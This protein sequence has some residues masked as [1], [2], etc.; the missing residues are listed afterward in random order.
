MLIEEEGGEEEEKRRLEME[1]VRIV[2]VYEDLVR[3]ESELEF[4]EEYTRS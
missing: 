3:V 4:V 2:L 1:G